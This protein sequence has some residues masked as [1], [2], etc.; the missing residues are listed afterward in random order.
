MVAH[1]LTVLLV[2]A[3][4]QKKILENKNNKIIALDRDKDVFVCKRN[5]KKNIKIDLNF[6]ILNFLKLIN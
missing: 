4:I 6:I 3:D 2:K 1:L 5:L